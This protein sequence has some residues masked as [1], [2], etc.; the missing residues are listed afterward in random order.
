[1]RVLGI[2]KYRLSGRLKAK[3]LTLSSFLIFFFGCFESEIQQNAASEPTLYKVSN[4]AWIGATATATN[5]FTTNGGFFASST[6][7]SLFSFPQSPAVDVIRGSLYVADP[8]NNEIVKLNLA[9]GTFVGAL[10]YVSSNFGN[11]PSSGVPATWCFGGLFKGFMGDGAFSSPGGIVL[12]LQRSFFYVSDSKNYRVAKYNL[13]TGAFVG[14]I[15]ALN[16]STGT[17]PSSGVSNTWCTGGR[18]ATSSVDG[19]LAD[20]SSIALDITHGYIYVVDTANNRAQIFALA[21]GAFVGAIGAVA[22]TT[23][24]CPSSGVTPGW[25]TGGSFIAGSADGALNT[26]GGIA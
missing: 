5:S 7:D 16:G 6:G 9:T 12:D 21:S 8:A 11:C 26:P 10:G 22:G 3:A 19:G 17:C 25:C 15:G 24:T 18:F 4:G 23:G 1:M 14:A 13:L 2:E 20:Q